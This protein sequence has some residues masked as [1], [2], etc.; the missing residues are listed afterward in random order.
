MNSCLKKGTEY[1]I[2]CMLGQGSFGQVVKCI[3]KKTGHFVAVKV[4]R[5]RP[6]YFRQGMLEIAI[7]TLLKEYYDKDGK[8][9]TVRLFDHFV[10]KNHIC[11]V[12]ELLGANIYELMKQNQCR[13]FN[14]N[15]SRSFL[16]QILQALSV[17]FTSN[18]IHCDLKPEN[19][20]L[21][22]FIHHYR[23]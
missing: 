9:N 13:G 8:G 3:D 12:T 22:E 19:V 5:N 11:I 7:L 1:Q 14:V 17:L 6:A 20:L 2:V 18:I 10:Y 16:Y 15:I 4:L 21:V 23:M